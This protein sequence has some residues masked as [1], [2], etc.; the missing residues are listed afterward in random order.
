MKYTFLLLLTLGLLCQCATPA[1]GPTTPTTV[2]SQVKGPTSP[3]VEAL[4]AKMTLDEKIGQL[5]LLTPG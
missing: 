2:K 4:L 1:V 3:T 5:N